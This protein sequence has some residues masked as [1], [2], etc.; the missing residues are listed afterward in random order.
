M[1]PLE[2]IRNA[3]SAPEVLSALAV[4]VESLRNVSAIPDWCLR[5]PLQDETD[6]AA[7]MLALITVV[8]LTSQHLRDQECNVAKR[9]LQV[10]AAATWRLRPK[11]PL[12]APR[13]AP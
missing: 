7:R 5:L 8:N 4:Y 2:L 3:N 12:N 9:A 11:R 1:D 13:R 10:F 6:V